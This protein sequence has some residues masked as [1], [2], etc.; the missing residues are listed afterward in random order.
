MSLIVLGTLSGIL[1]GGALGWLW[2][3]KFDAKNPHSAG[4]PC[5]SD[6]SY[7]FISTE[8]PC[9]EFVDTTEALGALEDKLE[10]K[11]GSYL[12]NGET[13]RISVWSRHLPTRRFVGVNTHE[14]YSPASLAK[15]PVAIAFFKYAEIDPAIL[16]KTVVYEGKRDLNTL[17]FYRPPEDKKLIAGASYSNIDLLERMLTYSDNNA[18]IMLY[19]QIDPAFVRRVNLD[20][21]IKIP[22]DRDP[23][24]NENFVTVKSYANLFRALYNASYLNQEFSEKI[25]SFLSASSFEGGARAGIPQSVKISHKFGER[26]IVNPNRHAELHDCGIVYNKNGPYTFCVMAEGENLDRLNWI[27]MDLSKTIYETYET[28]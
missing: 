4:D 5:E 12:L 6:I 28:K 24:P 21:G 14:T 3:E 16:N 18:T 19:Q 9:D 27:I 17:E 7:K 8:V 2:F 23:K 10:E 11:V 22:T 13:E 15:V 26:G 1:L 20:L 25:L